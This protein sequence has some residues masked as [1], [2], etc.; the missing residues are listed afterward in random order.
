MRH[1]FVDERAVITTTWAPSCYWKTLAPF[2]LQKKRPENAF[3]KPTAN[4]QLPQNH[5]EK[6]FMLSEPAVNWLFNGFNDEK[7][8]LVIG[9]FD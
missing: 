2:Y 6:Q 7:C 1:N 8:Y 5:T 3:L 9:C 4:C